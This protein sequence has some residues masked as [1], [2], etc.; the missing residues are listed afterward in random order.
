MGWNS[1]NCFANAVDTE[2]VYAQAKVLADSGLIKHGWTYVNIDDTWQG[3]RTGP[4]RALAANNKFPDMKGLVDRIHALGLKAGIYST[5]W[6]TSYAGY[7][8]GSAEN[9]AGAWT[10]PHLSREEKRAIIN[11]KILPYAVGRHHFMRAD[12]RQWAEWGFDY[13]KYDWNP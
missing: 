7:I 12:A 5:P 11:K 6:T 8:G 4:D 2:K 1:W 3:S 9:A 13:L 10:K